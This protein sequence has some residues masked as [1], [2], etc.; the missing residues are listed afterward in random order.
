M[1]THPPDW[2]GDFAAFRR[3]RGRF[4]DRLAADSL[5][6]SV[7][8]AA[9]GT[10]PEHQEPTM[11][12]IIVEGD[13]CVLTNQRRLVLGCFTPAQRDL[14]DVV[15]EGARVQEM[16]G[17]ARVGPVRITFQRLM[18]DVDLAREVSGPAAG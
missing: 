7:E 1:T 10:G 16:F 18:R 8:V 15:L 14:A 4:L 17:V 11:D 2:P 9:A 12:P 5:L 6:R 13:L 3:C